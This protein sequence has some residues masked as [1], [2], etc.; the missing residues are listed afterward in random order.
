MVFAQFYHL[1]DWAAE[2]HWCYTLRVWILDTATTQYLSLL[3][4]VLSSPFQRS[5][6]P[7]LPRCA[8][9]GSA[10]ST[11]AQGIAMH[12]FEMLR[13]A[14]P[15]PGNILTFILVQIFS[16]PVSTLFTSNPS[17]HSAF[18]RAHSFVS[19]RSSSLVIKMAIL[20]EGSFGTF[21]FKGTPW[22]V[23]SAVFLMGRTWSPT[24]PRYLYVKVFTR[25]VFKCVWEFFCG[26]KSMPDSLCLSFCI[27]W[28]SCAS[29]HCRE[30]VLQF[31][32]W[33]CVQIY[34]VAV[35]LSI[36]PLTF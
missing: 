21:W 36:K 30:P 7:Q 10:S 24:A 35:L 8:L 23:T 2:N 32:W 15:A 17:F 4:Q 28:I 16:W 11:M 26:E 33:T 12:N 25:M 27:F 3:C 29:G 22:A 14:S 9:E 5:H 1:L 19:L 20:T 18:K 13:W 31:W 6:T 34:L